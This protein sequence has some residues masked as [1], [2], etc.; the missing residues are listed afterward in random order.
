M[1]VY[2]AK[3]FFLPLK[4][5]VFSYFIITFVRKNGLLPQK[6]INRL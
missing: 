2:I 5:S 6:E 1:H 3:S 4:E